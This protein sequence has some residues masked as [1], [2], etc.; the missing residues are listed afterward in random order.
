MS[1][2]EIKITKED[3]VLWLDRP[4]SDDDLDLCIYLSNAVENQH[5]YFQENQK[6]KDKINQYENP[7]DLTLFYMWLDEKAKDKTKDL[8]RR[9]DKT[10]QAIDELLIY[11]DFNDTTHGFGNVK[12]E[13]KFYLSNCKTMTEF[14]IKQLKG[15][16]E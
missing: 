9:I 5:K 3:L 2:E 7:D 11:S 13:L 4:P 14:K 10:I 15:D 8:Q 16:V 1:E 6:L 12:D